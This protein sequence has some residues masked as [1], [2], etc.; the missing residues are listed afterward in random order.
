MKPFLRV[1]AFDD[2]WNGE[3]RGYVVHGS[4][5]LL[6]REDDRIYAYADRCAHQGVALSKGS[7]EGHVLTCSA[8]GWQYDVCTG[9]GVN[10]A[11]ARLEPLAV[12]VEHGT[13]FVDLAEARS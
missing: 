13:V 6:V 4:P 3:M 12:R 7:L 9:D 2:L 5:V 1:A 11:S 8:H 10:P